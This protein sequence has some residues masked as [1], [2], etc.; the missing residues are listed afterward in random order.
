MDTLSRTPANPPELPLTESEQAAL[1]DD[2]LHE[3]AGLP[4]PRGALIKRSLWLITIGPWGSWTH[5]VIPVDGNLD[6]PEPGAIAGWCDL[7][8]TFMEHGPL[9][10][11]AETA[12]V[13]LRR[14]GT[15]S[16]SDAD[17][18]IFRVLCEAVARRGTA[19]WAFYVAPTP[20]GA[21][22]PEDPKHA[23]LIDGALVP[24]SP[25]TTSRIPPARPRCRREVGER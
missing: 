5:A 25:Q 6:R 19:P 12:L 11:D 1:C 17:E 2:L 18:Y 13:V 9:F 23:G 15:A 8:A 21:H 16:L 4:L 20:H 10:D 7:I 14:P 22:E 3:L 24:T